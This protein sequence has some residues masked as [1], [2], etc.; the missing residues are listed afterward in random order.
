MGPDAERADF[1][2]EKGGIE[3]E[4]GQAEEDE[5]SGERK[6]EHEGDGPDAGKQQDR[7]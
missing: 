2:G 4:V 1:E 6:T 3:D 7:A 5:R